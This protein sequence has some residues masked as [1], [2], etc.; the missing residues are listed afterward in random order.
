[1]TNIQAF[2]TIYKNA[3]LTD[4]QMVYANGAEAAFQQLHEAYG[5]TDIQLV[6]LSQLL[7]G[8]GFAM[9]L[10]QLAE[11]LSM[12]L[13]S[14]LCYEEDL[15]ALCQRHIISH[16]VVVEEFAQTDKYCVYSDFVHALRE[17]VSYIATPH[18]EYQI[19]RLLQEIRSIALNSNLSSGSTATPLC[20]ELRNLIADTRHLQ[21]SR[22]IYDNRLNDHELR[23]LLAGLDAVYHNDYNQFDYSDCS[24]FFINR[25]DWNYA[26]RRSDRCHQ[27][28][29]HKKWLEFHTTEGAVSVDSFAFTR[30]FFEQVLP[31]YEY[32]YNQ[33]FASRDDKKLESNQG[34]APKQLYY[35]KREE[36]ELK[37]LEQL[38]QHAAFVE[39]QKRLAD[40]G[41]RSGFACLFYGAAGCGKTETV[42]QLARST[43]RSILRINPNDIQ[44]KFVGESEKNLKQAFDRYR[45]MVNDAHANQDPCPILLFN[46]AD[47]VFSRRLNKIASSV[48][49]MQNSLQNILLQEM[50]TLPGILIATTNLSENFD[51]AFERRFIYKIYFEK[52]TPEVASHIWQTMLPNLS[53]EEALQLA[54]EYPF[55]GGQI[56]NIARKQQVEYI[57]TGKQSTM[58]DLQGYCKQECLHSD[59]AIRKTIGFAA[60]S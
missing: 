46:E 23:I 11:E 45:R 21:F 28:C 31:E 9:S 35:N 57:L 56:E 59:A 15:N 4:D 25:S 3:H 32:L 8:T 7:N 2:N 13:L 41:F 12:S 51:S 48:D 40:S 47:A 37:Q 5:L 19:E 55:T 14:M 42:L 33:R 27:L 50:E 30:T 17:N 18:S 53:A 6:L 43:N 38:L 39:V 52:P 29:Q 49:Q 10:P 36:M 16:R 60:N 44:D 54:E 22:V 24:T 20:N 58:A 1:M 26:I 34:I